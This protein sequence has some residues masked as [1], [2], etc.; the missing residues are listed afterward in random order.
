MLWMLLATACQFGS[1]EPDQEATMAAAPAATQSPVGPRRNVLI[2]SMDTVSAEHMALYGGPAKTPNIARVA[3]Q[4]AL[5]S[6]ITHFPE[7]A[8]AHWTLMTGVLPAVHGNVPAHGTSRY[9][10]PTLAE[11]LKIQG[12]RTGA[13]IGGETLTDRSTGLSRGFDVYDDQYRWD[14]KDLRRPA[15]DVTR[16]AV[17]W[18]QGGDSNGQPYFAFVHYFDAHFPYTPAPPWDT[19]YL[20]NNPS[21]LGGSDAELRPYRD[22]EKNPSPSDIAKVAALYQGEISELD[23]AMAPLLNAAADPNTTVI[24]TA[25]HGESFGHDYWFNHRDGL[26]DEIIRVPLIWRDPGIKP[27]SDAPALRGLIDVVPTLLH[28]LNLPAIPAVHGSIAVDAATRGVNYAITDSE[29]PT[30][31]FAARTATHKLIATVANDRI[32]PSNQRRYDLQ[33]DPG[34]TDPN[35]ELPEAF[36]TTEADYQAAIQ[37]VIARSQGPKPER[38]TPDHAEHERLKALGYVDGPSAGAPTPK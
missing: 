17:N 31:Q 5:W 30:V 8:I 6:A 37:R 28:L 24:I 4:G 23:A 19:A 34:E 18:M 27:Q 9:T 25:D 36:E 11:H 35:A 33:T 3:E 21:R 14:R 38:R 32:Q 16:A 10:G 20:S 26:W 2:V 15:T 1:S 7:T 29:R 13:F 12:Y 22:G